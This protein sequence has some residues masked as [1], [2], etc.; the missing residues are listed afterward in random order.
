MY[1]QQ[2][3]GIGGERPFVIGRMC[4]VGCA[5]FNHACMREVHD[6]GDAEASANFDKFSSADYGFMFC[7]EF[8]EYH[9]NGSGIVV[10]S[11][12]SFSAC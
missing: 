11:E 5:N 2:H 7:S 3:G 10:H 9:H 1:L 4:L 12:S 6:V 8:R